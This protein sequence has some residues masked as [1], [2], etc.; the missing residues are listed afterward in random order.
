MVRFDPGRG[1]NGSRPAAAG[2]R[3]AVAAGALLAAVLLAACG[4]EED[5][6][7]PDVFTAAPQP[8]AG[9]RERDAEEARR[10]TFSANGSGHLWRGPGFR[11]AAVRKGAKVAVHERPGGR[12]VKRAGP[13][14]EFGSPLTFSVLGRR[15]RWL[16]VTTPISTENRPLWIV[17]DPDKL[18]FRT[19]EISIRVSLSERS[20][21]LREGGS[22]LDRFKVTIGTAGSSTPAGRFAVT[23]VIVGGLNPVYGCCAIAISAHQPNLPE[24]WIGGDRVAIHGTVGPVGSASSSGCIRVRDSDVESMA[25][26][27]PLGAP[28]F[29]K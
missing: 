21:E 15:G 5:P 4:G 24:D 20:L 26:L 10:P 28:V 2:A 25:G 9:D 19:T 12:I 23:D 22:A 6:A 13:K 16:R 8:R 7:A 11:I 18:S 3:L 14:T 29:I 27:I 1:G 17:A